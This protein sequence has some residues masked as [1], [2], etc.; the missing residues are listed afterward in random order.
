[1][2]DSHLQSICIDDDL[3]AALRQMT[4]GERLKIGFGLWR[5]ARDMTD[6]AVREEH[7]NWS[8]EQVHREV[9]YSVSEGLVDQ[10]ALADQRRNLILGDKSSDGS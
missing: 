6:R 3:F 5:F 7:A 4:D 8:D 1:M 10:S 2:D 9:A